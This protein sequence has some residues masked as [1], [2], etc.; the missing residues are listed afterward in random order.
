MT[1]ISIAIII[2][3][4]AAAFGG[5]RLIQRT[6]GCACAIDLDREEA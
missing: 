5:M 3:I 1:F 6:T 4:L 2:L